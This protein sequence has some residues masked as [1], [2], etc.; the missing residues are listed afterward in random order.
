MG[1]TGPQGDVGPVGPQG[2]QGEVGPTGVQGDPGPIGPQ[3]PQ[4]DVGPVGAQGPQGDTGPVGPQGDVGPAGPAGERGP[5][6]PQGPAGG[7]P[8]FIG[9]GF[10]HY[11][12]NVGIGTNEP[13]ARLHVVGGGGAAVSPIGAVLDGGD[14]SG[15]PRLELRKTAA[16]PYIDF[17]N[18]A[19]S[20]YDARLILE[21]DDTLELEGADLKVNGHIYAHGSS[22]VGDVAEPVLGN[23]L[24]PGDVVVSDGFDAAGKLQVRRATEALDRMVIGVISTNPS[25]TLAGLPTDT[26]LAVSGIVPV[27]IV[28]QVVA[29]DLLASSSVPGHAQVC[30]P[31]SCGGAVIGK[32]LES[33]GDGDGLVRM[34]VGLG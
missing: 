22:H 32:A 16:S 29:G 14:V 4:G 2:P 5:E 9:S 30:Q 33:D 19:D 21:D 7:T 3:G 6:G 18:D 10:T 15:N 20:D 28:G 17:A 13:A 23:D 25:I 24:Q 27:K 1:A 34:I 12:G 26:P 8:W 31:A 11:E